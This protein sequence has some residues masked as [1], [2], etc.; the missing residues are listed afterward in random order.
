[1]RTSFHAKQAFVQLLL[2]CVL[3]PTSVVGALELEDADNFEVI[4][5]WAGTSVGVP[6]R[7]GAMMFSDDGNT[8]YVVG[9]AELANSALY[10]VA[11]SRDSVTGQ[12]TD[13]G[14][15]ESTTLV[16]SGSLAG[17]DTGLEIGPD[18]T[19]FYTY[20]D[21]NYIGQRPGGFGGDETTYNMATVGVPP[22]VAGLTFSPH[23]DDLNTGFG[24][25]QVSSWLGDDLYN[26]PLTPTDGGLFEPGTAVLFVSLP[27]QG[28]GAIQYVPSGLLEGNLMYVNWDFGEIR[29]L[30]ID[31]ESGLPIDADS[32]EPTLG[33]TN[34]VDQRFAYDIGVGPWGLEFDGR[35]G[36][37]FV[38]TWEG[39]PFNSIIQLSGP[40]FTN[41][42]GGTGGDGGFGGEGGAGGDGT[43]SDGGGCGCRIQE[44]GDGAGTG[45]LVGI[46]A[47]FLLRNRRRKA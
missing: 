15:A 3:L 9:D 24:Q 1:M 31:A 46:V 44:P 18:G 28:T 8:L 4:N 37:F 20:W 17:L 10:A 33:T 14:P 39:D 25:M 6:G 12:V 23:V 11:V 27:Q 26:V 19:L 41:G 45:L 36:D 38:S 42:T 29:V 5:V 47:L 30:E 7:L 16:F 21:A 13:L 32:G 2:A 35:S 43:P 40:G 34:P 22:S